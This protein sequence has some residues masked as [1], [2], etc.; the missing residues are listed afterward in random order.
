MHSLTENITPPLP[1]IPFPGLSRITV[2]VESI[3]E[4]GTLYHV[5]MYEGADGVIVY[6]PEDRDDEP[7]LF[8][9]ESM[10]WFGTDRIVSID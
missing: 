6:I 1:S 4:P 2:T 7:H 9:R 10:Q 5:T 3:D 8:R